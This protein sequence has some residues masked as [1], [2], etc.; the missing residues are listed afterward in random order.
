M[1]LNVEAR[2]WKEMLILFREIVRPEVFRDY[3]FTRTEFDILAQ[4]LLAD[5]PL[6]QSELLKRL[7]TTKGNVSQMLQRLEAKGFVS[8]ELNPSDKRCQ[9]VALT[10]KGRE[11]IRPLVER[12][13]DYI[14]AFFSSLTELEKEFLYKLL[15]KISLKMN[16]SFGE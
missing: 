15:R 6:S 3:G 12:H 2:I 9:T 16:G 5:H 10:D 1:E 8:R 13:I 4:L 7:L 11:L 14:S